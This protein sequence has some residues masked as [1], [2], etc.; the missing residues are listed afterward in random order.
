MSRTTRGRFTLALAT[1]LVFFA[2]SAPAT[3]L[4]TEV[5]PSINT[6]GTSGD[7]VELYNTGPGAVDLTGYILTDLDPGSVEGD[8]TQEGTFAEG[9]LGLPALQPG[10]FAVVV[11]IDQTAVPTPSFQV[12]NFGL[13]IYSPLA[14]GA[15]SF[16]S[17]SNEELLLA[18]DV[19]AALDFVA[20]HDTAN[21]AST[22][23]FDDLA[24]VSTPTPD[25]GLTLTNDSAWLAPD[26]IPDEPTYQ[27]NTLDNTGYD[28]ASTYGKSSIRRISTA[29]VF[30][31]GAPDGPANWEIVRREDATLGNFSDDVP[32]GAGIRPIRITDDLATWV[33]NLRISFFPERRIATGEDQMPSDFVEPSGGN[34]TTFESTIQQMLLGNWA[35][36]FALADTIGYEVVEF[37]DTQTGDTFYI[38]RER[39]VPGDASYQGGGTVIIDPNPAARDYLVLEVPHPINDS[40]TLAE[41]GLAV[42]QVR[43]LVTIIAGTHRN[44]STTLT[45]CDGT[46]QN[47]DPY[48]ISDVAHYATSYFHHTH[49]L[50]CSPPST[51]LAIQLHGFCCEIDYSLSDD[52]VISNGFNASP[53]VDEFARLWHDAIDA[54]GYDTGGGDITTA[55]LYGDGGTV[56]GG[57]NNLQ[58]RIINGV[59]EGD[60]CTN[61]AVGA[62]GQF[63]HIEQDPEV[64]N[65][66]Q[67]VIDAL[68]SALTT[69][70]SILAGVSDWKIFE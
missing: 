6:T 46:F 20:W 1:G 63:I 33:G 9:S 11:F 26:A 40:N 32:D 17:S 12:T 57:T 70:E 39:F 2:S 23:N 62:S 16:L 7:T 27:A 64:R 3:L 53:A 18:D 13:R 41:A 36:A 25:Y 45:T 66:P 21:A 19:G 42:P 31:E 5:I 60:E 61:A 68:N 30:S 47:G 28:G 8:I 24:A 44:N 43:P 10:E 52:I 56:L 15:N 22:D 59:A 48:H 35:D 38:L 58:G 34:L 29:G 67:H 65:D 51:N 37:L 54:L 4:I 69:Y 55:V 49:K 50:F 14:T